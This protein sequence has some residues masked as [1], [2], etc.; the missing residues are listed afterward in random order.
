MPRPA[1]RARASTATI[2][3]ALAAALGAQR[4]RAV[5]GQRGLVERLAGRVGG[6]ELAQA[7]PVEG[8]GRVAVGRQ[9]GRPRD[10]LDAP[11]P[12]L[13]QQRA[14]RVAQ[15]V[16]LALLGRLPAEGVL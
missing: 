13:A 8:V 4:D 14:E 11:A 2:I 1:A 3:A 16:R 15:A 10:A 9:P 12:A 6:V 7:R 5:G